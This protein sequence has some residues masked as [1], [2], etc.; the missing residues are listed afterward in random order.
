MRD[1]VVCRNGDFG[2]GCSTSYVGRTAHILYLLRVCFSH[3]GDDVVGD[4]VDFRVGM[5]DTGDELG[6]G[7]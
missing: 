2:T 5:A 1:A 6:Q 3:M 4:S 7:C